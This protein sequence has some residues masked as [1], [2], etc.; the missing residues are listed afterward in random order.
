MGGHGQLAEG[1]LHEVLA[2]LTGVLVGA[3]KRPL[4]RAE[5]AGWSGKYHGTAETESLSTR[6]DA[7]VL[8]IRRLLRVNA[9]IGTGGVTGNLFQELARNRFPD[10]PHPPSSG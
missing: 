8:H 3:P 1:Q 9:A 5:R 6:G 2:R 10:K 4:K 7:A